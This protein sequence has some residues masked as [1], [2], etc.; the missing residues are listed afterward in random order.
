MHDVDA[1]EVTMTQ[2]AD[3][4]HVRMTPEQASALLETDRKQRVDQAAQGV[5]RVLQEWRCDLIAVAQ[6]TQD[7][8]ISTA[9]QI[10]AR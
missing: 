4:G 3:N 1:T 9:V 10:V 8:R 6:L 7:G 5:Q 2:V